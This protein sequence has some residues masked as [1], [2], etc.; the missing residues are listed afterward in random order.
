MSLSKEDFKEC[1]SDECKS[2]GYKDNKK[3]KVYLYGIIVDGKPCIKP[4]I[5]IQLLSKRFPQYWF[6]EHPDQILSGQLFLFAVFECD[7]ST[8]YQVIERLIKNKFKKDFG[9]LHSSQ[10]GNTEQ[11]LLR[12]DSYKLIIK[13]LENLNFWCE[14]IYKSNDSNDIKNQIQFL[15]D[16]SYSLD[17]PSRL[18]EKIELE[19]TTPLQRLKN[20]TC[21][22]LKLIP[23]I[24]DKLAQ[25]ILE[26]L[27]NN[28]ILSFSELCKIPYFG[29]VK[30]KAIEKY[31]KNK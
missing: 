3:H 31:F 10:H 6:D 14:K 4:G 9:P 12:E 19:T 1:L 13:I 27:R 29:P 17:I 24:G 25:K 7:Q 22:E 8:T 21:N 2:I 28:D 20:T 11:Y 5:T 16:N 18:E 23:K 26:Y 30:L 15:I